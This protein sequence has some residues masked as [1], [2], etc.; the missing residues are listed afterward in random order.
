M[1]E[2]Q[3]DLIRTQFYQKHCQEAALQT[4]GCR[5]CSLMSKVKK[6]VVKKNPHD[7]IMKTYKAWRLSSLCW[8]ET[9]QKIYFSK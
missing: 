8:D 6:K 9:L 2:I 7:V 5:F 4:P 1:L 3:F